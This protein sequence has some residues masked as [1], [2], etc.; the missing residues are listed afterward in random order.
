MSDPNPAQPKPRLAIPHPLVCGVAWAAFMG[1][2][3]LA[4]LGVKYTL[5]VMAS[6]PSPRFISADQPLSF[7]I[8]LIQ[9]FAIGFLLAWYLRRRRAAADVRS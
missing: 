5:A 8:L 3:G 1:V 4:F 2:L 9:S 7:A 6:E